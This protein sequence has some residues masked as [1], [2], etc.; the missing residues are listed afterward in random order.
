MKLRLQKCLVGQLNLILRDQRR[1]GR[2]A[3]CVLHHF[4]VL[5]SAQQHAQCRILMR[6]ADAAV[7]RLQIETQLPQIFGLEAPDLQ[8]DRH[9]AVEPAME[10]KE[11]QRKI[12]LANLHRKLGANKAEVA[13]QLDQEVPEPTQQAL[14]QVRLAVALRQAE[15]LE[16]VSIFED[17]ERLWMTLSHHW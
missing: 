2:A 15:K 14:V 1:R 3:Q 8:F 7:Q 9:Q 11:I 10:E 12:L 4:I 17:A 13:P 6:L 16:Q 5:A